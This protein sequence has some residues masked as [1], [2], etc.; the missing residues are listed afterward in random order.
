MKSVK[1][2]E[3]GF[4][5]WADAETCKKCGVALTPETTDTTYQP[6]QLGFVEYQPS[7][8]PMFPGQVKKGLAICSL[9]IGIVNLFTFGFLGLGIIV[10]VILSI[11]ALSKIRQNPAVYGGRELAIAGLVTNIV[12]VAVIVPIA[13]IA[14]IAIPNFNAAR[15]AAYEGS[16]IYSLRE[17]HA[18]EATYQSRHENFGTLDDLASENL[19]RPD[20]ASGTR[21]GYK[22]K[23]EMS[24]DGADGLAGFAATGVPA[25]YPNTGRRS[26]YVDETGVIRA[27][28]SQGGKATKLDLPLH[29]DRDDSTDPPATRTRYDQRT[30][31]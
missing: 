14:A 8:Q 27:A 31:R 2:S 21:N 1:C 26:F 7:S 5:G 9:V 6:H 17:I 12:S 10:G 20:L 19:I 18:A 13:I 3:C 16:A 11:V 25:N 15:R 29:T 22:F 28:D 23:I 30:S 24:Q 4:V